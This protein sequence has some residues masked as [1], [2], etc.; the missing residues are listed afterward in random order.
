MKF[1]VRIFHFVEVVHTYVMSSVSKRLDIKRRKNVVVV[2]SW[3]DRSHGSLLNC[4]NFV[5]MI[6]RLRRA[7]SR[8][9]APQRKSGP[10]TPHCMRQLERNINQKELDRS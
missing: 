8:H 6:P 9:K 3:A 2:H 5:L 10:R 7:R 1:V 4:F